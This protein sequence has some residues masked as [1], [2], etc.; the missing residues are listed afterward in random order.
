MTDF[1]VTSFSE[2]VQAECQAA[3]NAI[4]PST[5]DEVA[6][7]LGRT[8]LAVRPAVSILYTSGVLAKTGVKRKNISGVLAHE[9]ALV[10]P[11]T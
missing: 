5:A 2:T 9:W 10:K 7:H 4:G 11:T 6:T 3:F 8:V 1:N